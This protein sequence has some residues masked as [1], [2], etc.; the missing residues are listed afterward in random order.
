METFELVPDQIVRIITAEKSELE[1][2]INSAISEEYQVNRIV[3]KI[4]PL[5]DER[6]LILFRFKNY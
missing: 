4:I 3:E 6:V 5:S 1:N 2:S